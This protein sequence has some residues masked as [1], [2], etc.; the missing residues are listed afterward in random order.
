MSPFRA[1]LILASVPVIVIEAVP[2]AP[3]RTVMPLVPPNVS[4]PSRT[5]KVTESDV[6][7]AAASVTEIGSLPEL[8]N[9]QEAFSSTFSD[10][11]ALTDGGP[12]TVIATAAD[13]DRLSPE[14]W[15]AAGM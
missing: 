10:V 1:A 9:V 7:E 11:G 15:G 6:P 8:E 4:L 5:A 13:V 3:A 14:S 12:F 2:L